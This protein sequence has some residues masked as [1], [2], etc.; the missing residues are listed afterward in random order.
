MYALIQDGKVV[1]CPY[2]IGKL[3]KDNPNTSFPNKPTDELFASFDVQPV[4]IVDSPSYTKRTQWVTQNT[5]PTLVDEVWVLGWTVSDKTTDE[6]A[7]Y[8]AGEASTNRGIRN[9]LLFETD[10]TA[11]SDV[12]MADNMKTYRQALRDLPTHSN[13]PNLEDNDWPTKP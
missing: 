4:T 8:D 3:R 2:T 11:M 12:T 7:E 13:W 6:I 5:A 10:W 9:S 1:T